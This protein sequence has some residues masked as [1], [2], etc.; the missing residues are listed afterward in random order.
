MP[1]NPILW[2]RAFAFSPA[3]G[4]S[5]ADFEDTKAR[6]DS[7]GVLSRYRFEFVPAGLAGQ[8][9]DVVVHALPANVFGG[10]PG[11]VVALARGFPYQTLQYDIHNIRSAGLNLSK[12]RFFGKKALEFLPQLP[13]NP[14]LGQ[15]HGVD[16]NP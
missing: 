8:D 12:K 2:D 10:W 11:A 3:A 6:L 4:L 7:L 5:L 9:F 14:G 1:I 16:R 13:Q 15:E